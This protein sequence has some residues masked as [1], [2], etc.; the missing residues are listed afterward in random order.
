MKTELCLNI[1]LVSFLNPLHKKREY[2]KRALEQLKD[3]SNYGLTKTT[4]VQLMQPSY[5]GARL[6]FSN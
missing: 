2:Q 5:S 6:N 3:Y 4:D 1:R